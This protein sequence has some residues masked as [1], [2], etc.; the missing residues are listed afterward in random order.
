MLSG[1]G[2]RKKDEADRGCACGRGHTRR[3]VLGAAAGFTS[4]PLVAGRV[5]ASEERVTIVHDLHTHGEIGGVGGVNIAHYRTAVDEQLA[6][7]DSVFLTS[8]DELG[9]SPISF[10]TKGAHK[11]DFMNE[12][13][14]TA[15]GVGNHDFDCGVD[16]ATEQFER[17]EFPWLSSA[18]FTPEGDPLPGTERWRT[19][20]VSDITLGLFNVVL[21]GFHAITD[22]P[23]EYEARDPVEVSKEMVE[24]LEGEGAD[25]IVL[26]SHVGHSTHYEIAEAVDGLDAIVGSHSHITFDEAEIH[27]NTV[28]SEIGYAYA[29]LGVLRLD[30]D[31][32]FR[33][34]ERID[35]G[36]EIDPDPDFKARLEAQ[37][38]RF[39]DRF[40][41]VVGETGV[42]L[43]AAGSVNY[44]RE[45]R[46]G[47]LITDAM[48]AVGDVDVAF[49]NAG[50]IRTNDTYEAGPLTVSDILGILPFRERLVVFEATGEEIE[51]GLL[52]R[53]AALPGS[54]FGA[55]PQ[56]QVSGL[57]YEWSGHEEAEIGEVYIDGEPLD[58][59]GVYTVSTTE[60]IKNG[61]PSFRDS[62]IL[63]DPETYLA[64]AVVDYI[65][66]RGRVEP[67]IE[68]RILRIDADVG[69]P[70]EWESEGRRTT[71]WFA[72]PDRASAI[73]PESFFMWSRFG[74]RY[75]PIGIERAGDRVGVTFDAEVWQRIVRGGANPELRVFGGFIPD[76]E[77]YGYRDQDG[78]CRKLP[79]VGA[80][81]WFVVK[82]RVAPS[83]RSE[84]SGY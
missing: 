32:A 18:L 47:N 29:H 49:Q 30:A 44:A 77:R 24:V 67:A 33:S 37:Y 21:R 15:A 53:V 48:C 71:A 20:E 1:R 11:V 60:F 69:E 65:E 9:P 78:V 57:S 70:V 80:Y 81:D 12:M 58:P 35:L 75:E 8:G 55:Q 28:I 59:D 2:A 7:E 61:Y 6:S 25:V 16:V 4:A 82:G 14:I 39:D 36:E 74:D 13:N 76:S 64:S 54:A 26:V 73:A 3:A 56:Q 10:F 31:G 72:L 27:S 68:G 23:E 19:V 38:E 34:W 42:A 17:S 50:G 83:D 40:S 45:S 84:T 46:L 52:T 79:V 43:T 5:A 41:R 63:F 51:A 62:D 22:Y 66:E